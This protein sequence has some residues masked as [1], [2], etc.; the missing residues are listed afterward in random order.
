VPV[1]SRK[2]LTNL[3]ELAEGLEDR[4]GTVLQ[5]ATESVHGTL[6]LGTPVLTGFARSN[7][8][9]GTNGPPSGTVPIRSE[10]ET[11]ESGQSVI[12]SARRASHFEIVNNAH[13][14][15]LLN[16]GSSRKAPAGFVQKAIRIGLNIVKQ[17][18]I[19]RSG[20]RY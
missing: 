9:V 2:Y 6:V 4:V 18:R 13:Y 8:Q 5:E 7:W 11:I 19:L 15:G 20:T 10:V 3:R 16:A 14:I 12:R 1:G 17:R